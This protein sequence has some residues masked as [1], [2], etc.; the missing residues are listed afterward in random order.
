LVALILLLIIVAVLIIVLAMFVKYKRRVTLTNETA[1]VRLA[2]LSGRSPLAYTPGIFSR[3][4]SFAHH[5]S[6]SRDF[7]KRNWT[8]WILVL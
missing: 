1:V 6:S 3:P 7:F 4:F 2:S 8:T 5:P